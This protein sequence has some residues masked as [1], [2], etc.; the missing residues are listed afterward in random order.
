MT[1]GHHT[2]FKLI[3][4]Y[5]IL[6]NSNG[7]FEKNLGIIQSEEKKSFFKPVV[8]TIFKFH[9]FFFQDI[10]SK[11]CVINCNDNCERQ[12]DSMREVM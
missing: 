6:A 4:S 9:D 7:I 1:F 10:L 11:E 8:K 5:Y 3:Y 12:N 2:F